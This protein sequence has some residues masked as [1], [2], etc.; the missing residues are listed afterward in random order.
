MIDFFHTVLYTP[1]Y[2]LLIGLTD[3]LPGHDIGLAVVVATLIVKVIIMP[4]SFAALRTQR[5]VKAMEPE[6][7]RIREEFKVDR[8]AQARE[9]LALYKKYKVNPFASILTLLIQFPVLLTLYWVFNSG[10]LLTVQTDILYS[11]VPVPEYIAPLFLGIFAVSG[12][13]VILAL[14]AGLTQL[15]YGWYAIPVPEKPKE[16]GKSMQADMGRALALQMRFLLPLV[17]CVAA[18]FTSVAIALYFITS[19]LVGIAQ[20]FIIRRKKIEPVQ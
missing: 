11:F 5:A 20:E 4:L 10:S 13:S 1:I 2:N 17:I 16:P 9:M 19:N 7:K 14:L 15:A 3:I 6:M 8:E 12:A 18:Y